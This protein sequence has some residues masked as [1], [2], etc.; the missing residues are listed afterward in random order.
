MTWVDRIK[1][2]HRAVFDAPEISEGLPLARASLWGK[3]YAEVYGTKPAELSAVLVLRHNGIAM[4]MGDDYWSRFAIGKEAGIKGP[5][6]EFVTVNPD[7]KAWPEVPEPWRHFNLEQFRADGGI[8][9]ACNL[10]F[11]LN[12]VPRYQKAGATPE[13]A[14][15]Q[16][17]KDLLPGVMLMPSGFFAVSCAQEAGC[18]FIPAS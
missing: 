2:K 11:L 13:E 12:A 15:A 10:A 8:V 16:A 17:K 9:L 3:Q 6:G 7:R 1:G 18:Q 5:S 14:L 4:A